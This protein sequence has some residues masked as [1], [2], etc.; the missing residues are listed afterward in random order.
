MKPNRIVQLDALRA[1]AIIL[2][3]NVHFFGALIPKNY[4]VEKDSFLFQVFSV[5]NAGAIGVDLFF[6]ISGYLIYKNLVERSELSFSV[7]LTKRIRRLYPVFFISVVIYFLRY[8][9]KSP[10]YLLA[11]FTFTASL[12]KNVINYNHV[13]WSLLYEWLFYISAFFIIFTGRRFFSNIKTINLFL[14]LGFVLCT[15]LFVLS[16]LHFD[17]VNVP[18]ADRMMN[19]FLGALLYPVTR[20]SVTNTKDRILLVVCFLLIIFLQFLFTKY[21]TILSKLYLNGGYFIAAGIIFL[22]LIYLVLKFDFKFLTNKYLIYLGQISYSFYLFHQIIINEVRGFFNP[23]SLGK[24]VFVYFFTI[25]ATIAVAVGSYLLFE[26]PGG[27]HKVKEKLSW[28]IKLVRSKA[29]S[30]IK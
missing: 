11:N 3:F 10:Q 9:Y 26:A 24:M 2:V 15:C 6:V 7:F 23:Q 21:W 30:P 5:L 19:I 28:L 16:Q 27:R 29:K 18:E 8:Y 22:Y 1:F 25:G 12:F 13:T 20:S 14:I 17:S 4:F